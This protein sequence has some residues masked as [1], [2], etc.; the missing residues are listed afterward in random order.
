VILGDL[1]GGVAGGITGATLGEQIDDNVLNRGANDTL[2]RFRYIQ[3]SAELLRPSGRFAES[4][5]IGIRP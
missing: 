5:A 3:V 4:V 2:S 1:F